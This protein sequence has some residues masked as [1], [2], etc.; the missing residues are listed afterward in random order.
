MLFAQV[1]QELRQNIGCDHGRGT[2]DSQSSPFRAG[3][4]GNL[5]NRRI[6]IAE[7]LTRSLQQLLAGFS[8]HHATWRANKQFRAQLIFQLSDLHTNGGLGDVNAL[9]AGGKCP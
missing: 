9:C 3:Q 7:D 1:F 5:I 2:A 6:V 4:F 8:K